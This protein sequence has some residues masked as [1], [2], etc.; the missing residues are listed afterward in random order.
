MKH[1]VDIPIIDEQHSYILDKISNVKTQK[2]LLMIILYIKD[3]FKDEEE[4]MRKYID[5]MENFCPENKKGC[6]HCVNNTCIKSNILEHIDIHIQLQNKLSKD[7]K[8]YVVKNESNIDKEYQT[9]LQ[10]I[11][12]EHIYEFDIKTFNMM[13]KKR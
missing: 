6:D 2:D 5:E 11:L 3:H 13:K 12:K 10:N 7:I 1:L 4:Y 8:E 9:Y